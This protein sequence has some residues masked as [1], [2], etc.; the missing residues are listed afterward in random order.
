MLFFHINK[1]Q[2]ALHMPK[3]AVILPDFI[4]AC[5]LLSGTAVAANAVAI[6][7]DFGS[8]VLPILSNSCFACHGPDEASRQ[9]DLRLDLED[10][11]KEWAVVEGDVEG[12]EIISRILSDDPD[13]RMPPP[14]SVQKISPEETE[15]LKAW[16]AAGAAWGK[17]WSFEAPKRPE[18]PV[19]EPAS[20]NRNAIDHFVLRKLQEQSL[21]PSEQ[22]TRGSLIRR[23]TLDLTGLPP[24]LE[25]VDAFLA[26][27][28]PKAYENVVDRLLASPRYGEHMAHPWLA[29][30]RYA[31]TNGYQ[32]DAT[33]TMWPWRDWVIRAMNSNMPFD[34][35]TVD[36]LAGDLLPN[37]TQD[38][39]LATGFHRNHGLN[40]EGGRNPEESRVEYVIDRTETTGT[41][42]LGLTAGCSRCHDHKY[43]PLPQK[44][45]YRLAAYFNNIDETGGVDSGGNAKPVMRL[46]TDEQ[47]KKLAA[48]NA[49]IA[50][51]QSELDN[52]QQPSPKQQ[53]QWEK[54]LS[55]WL[56]KSRENELWQPLQD[57]KFESSLGSADEFLPDGS[58]LVAQPAGPNDHFTITAV[59]AGG[60]YNS[61]RLE[62]FRDDR[63]HNGQFSTDE[64]GKFVVSE[65]YARVNGESLRLIDARSDLSSDKS[66]HR[67]VDNTVAMNWRPPLPAAEVNRFSLVA[68]FAQPIVLPEGGT[69]EV[70]L[71]QDSRD[72]GD[73][74]IGRF[75]LSV[76]DYPRAT[77]DPNLDLP[78]PL[79]MALLTK[80]NE[81]TPAQ[82]ELLAEQCALDTKQKL[83]DKLTALT[84]K[85]DAIHSSTLQTM[86]MRDREKPRKTYLLVRGLWNQPDKSELLKPDVPACLPP[87]PDDAPSNRLA[88]A[89]WLV[90]PENPLVARVTV[91]R[92]WQHFFGRG[93]VNTGED[94]GLQGERP[95]HPQ[96]L[97]WLATEFVRTGWDVKAMHKL[98][99]TSAAY[100][101]TSKVSP[102][103]LNGD[104]ANKWISRGPRFRLTAQAI[105]DQALALSG[106]LVHQLGGE[107]VLPYQPDGVWSDFSLGKI[108]YKQG[109]GDDLYRRSVYTFWRRPVGPTMFFDN[110]GRQVCT[111][112]T[113]R[114]N[115][116]LHALTTLNDVTYVEAA[117]VL[118]ERLMLDE[119]L[120]SP[121]DRIRLAFRSATSR[122]PSETEL[123]PFMNL[124]QL[125]LDEY[126]DN[127]A[128]ADQL[129]NVGDSTL[130]E[131]INRPE[132]AALTGVMNAI[133]NLDEV[134]TKG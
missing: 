86:V 129:L 3:A 46:P 74:P 10:V 87:L 33:R 79:L 81:R 70:E 19:V 5:V 12:S 45:F 88:L 30:A 90:A 49:E 66:A 91:N 89:R 27:E 96:L 4:A 103:S 41:V 113:S 18:V 37:P 14:E 15:T 131:G 128:A 77:L 67:A 120:E 127:P 92:Y 26:D 104:P 44:D 36:Q 2:I 105:R 9:A 123:Q 133:L 115:T 119:S 57:P 40:G 93:L 65:I 56:T 99:V 72:A 68:K 11:A 80:P 38:Q 84:A 121:T 60:T 42:W 108:K 63:L 13:L 52:I 39:L 110:L 114:T 122:S 82:S 54:Q 28:S 134:L 58:V 83:A 107:P 34:K 62:A 132:T 95:S 7:P 23:V 17:H 85:I 8:Q 112:R 100:Q 31:D 69:L 25:E 116:P 71:R 75:R 47:Q 101:Q 97:D 64:S 51:V 126:R 109:R 20:W 94:F 130:A 98:I 117:R 125:L 78:Q 106:L 59:L 35:F 6:A 118:A 22:A 73:V 50:Q 1:F 21:E 61:L 43:D 32:T 55:G 16:I 124:Y 111:V 102:A 53:L 48:L 76:S 24:S 29:A